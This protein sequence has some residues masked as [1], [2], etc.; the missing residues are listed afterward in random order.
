MKDL[1]KKLAKGLLH[2]QPAAKR[3]KTKFQIC[4][5]NNSIIS[6]DQDSFETISNA[7]L[8]P[9]YDAQRMVSTQT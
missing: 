7:D 5:T 9:H 4:N 1:R 2:Q 6:Y 3:T 8:N